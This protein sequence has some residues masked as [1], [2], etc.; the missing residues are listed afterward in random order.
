[1]TGA[2]NAPVGELVPALNADSTWWTADNRSI[3][4]DGTLVPV[5][6]AAILP[7][8]VTP[9]ERA[10]AD[11]DGRLDDIDAS[12]VW[13]AKDPWQA[14]EWALPYLA[15][16]RSVDVW[17]PLWPEDVKRAAVAAAPIVHRYK[18]TPHGLK[19]ALGALGVEAELVEWWQ[20]TPRAAP[21]TFRVTAYARTLLYGG[22][23][24]L[25]PRLVKT[26][27]A[28]VMRTKPLSRAFSLSIGAG[29]TPGLGLAAVAPV[30]LRVR[31]SVKP[32]I[33]YPF[34]SRLGAAGAAVARIRVRAAMRLEAS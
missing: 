30:R 24:F 1:M 4:V 32:K 19:T 17:D 13:R 3:T 16:E 15:W 11:V 2:S 28:T 23:T 14:P 34:G 20:T 18:G 5:E 7:P 26:I 21:Y 31:Q 33:F 8:A 6:R 12:T 9:I 25:D 10:I 22:A 29:F 27:Y